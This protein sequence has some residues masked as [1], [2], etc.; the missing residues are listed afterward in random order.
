MVRFTLSVLQWLHVYTWFVFTFCVLLQAL[1]ERSPCAGYR[2]AQERHS[3]CGIESIQSDDCDTEGLQQIS[4]C[5][6]L[7]EPSEGGSKHFADRLTLLQSGYAR[8]A[9][10]KLSQR[11]L[12]M[13]QR[14][15]SGMVHEKQLCGG[16]YSSPMPI[17]KVRTSAREV[18]LVFLITFSSLSLL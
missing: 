17:G 8:S 2:K 18:K 14:S 12:Q 15:S 9:Q 16:V 13:T 1:T 11:S 4:H 10:K 7:L 5:S 6:S 3:T